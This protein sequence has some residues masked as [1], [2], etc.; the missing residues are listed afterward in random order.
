MQLHVTY[1]PNEFGQLQGGVALVCGLILGTVFVAN[2]CDCLRR[3]GLAFIVAA[4]V[5]R[6]KLH[7]YKLY[8]ASRIDVSLKSCYF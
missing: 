1:I 4:F 5:H 3:C 7:L 6:K 2:S 8:N